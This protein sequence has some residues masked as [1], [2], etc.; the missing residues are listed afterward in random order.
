MM[1]KH[2]NQLKMMQLNIN[3]CGQNSIVA[4]NRYINKEKADV[5]F[6]SE[7]KTSSLD[8]SDFDNYQVILKPNK[9]KPTQRGGTAI[10]VHNCIAA[11]RMEH[12]EKENTD[13]TFA[14]L[15]LDRRRILVCSSYVPPN[16]LDLLR[17]TEEQIRKATCEMKSLRCSSFAAFGDFNSRHVQWKDH[18]TNKHGEEL[19]Q[20]CS[21]NNLHIPSIHSNKTFICNTG[22]SLIDIAI[23]DHQTIKLITNQ[24]VDDSEELFTG[25][26]SRGHIPVWTTL[27][28]YTPKPLA[29]T[30][31]S[32]S[33]ADWLGF[34][35]HLETL[36][37]SCLFEI[38]FL[39]P[40]E[41]WHTILSNLHQCKELFVPKI[42]ISKY[43]KPY[44][45]EELTELSKK[46]REARKAFRHRSTYANGDHLD[47]T[48][49]KFKKALIEAQTMFIESKSANLN[50]AEDPQFWKSF[51]QTFY[52]SAEP[53][54]TAINKD[55]DLILDD[56]KKADTFFEEIFGG[57]H[58]EG[59]HFSQSW[60]EEVTDNLNIHNN[61]KFMD[62]M[63]KVTASE[64]TDAIKVTKTNGK[65]ADGDGIHPSMLKLSG[66]QFHI[67]LLVLFNKIL[68]TRRWPFTDNN[69]VVF[70]RKPGRKDYTDTANYRPITLSSV[71]GKLLERIIEARLRN[72]IEQ[73]NWLGPNQH[74]FRKK[75]STGTYLSQLIT[76][77]QHNT[78]RHYATAGLF[79]DLQKAFDSVW[80]NGMIYRLAE[81]GFGGHFIELISS[82]LKDR[83]IK[84]RV[85]G[86]TSEAKS[87]HIGL[88]QGSVLSPL[89]F[90]V[91]IRDMLSSIDGLSLQYADDCSIVCSKPD[92]RQLQDTLESSCERIS[93]WLCKWRLKANCLKTD[94]I[95][96]KGQPTQ[97]KISGEYINIASK[98]KVLGVVVD[99]KL[100]FKHQKDVAK[101][102]LSRKWRMLLPFI[103][104]GLRPSV[105][106]K[107]LITTIL[108]K[109]LY[110][111]YIWDTQ[112]EMSL[113]SCLKDLLGV[114]FNPATDTL[115]KLANI[116]TIHVRYTGDIL[117][118]C[119]LSIEGSTMNNILDQKKSSLQHRIRCCIVRLLGRHFEEYP[120]TSTQFKKSNVQKFLKE[121]ANRT[122][123]SHLKQG[124]N[125][126]GLLSQLDAAH[127][128]KVPVPLNLPRQIIGKLCSLLTGQTKLQAFLYKVNQ[129]Y[130]PTCSCLME[131]E[132]VSHYVYRCQNYQYLR[133]R[134]YVDPTDHMSL[135]SYV[136]ES[137]RLNR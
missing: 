85:N 27:D 137:G 42:M 67:N 63:S 110:N 92:D 19:L 127:L 39:E 7:T 86:H 83:K 81:L 74:G 23:V 97:M 103:R 123:K 124:H 57:K 99:Q 58:L 94:V 18:T 101:S 20:F 115:H 53:V 46:V 11:D 136:K 4:L 13:T 73:N 21:N 49:E 121:E 77:I 55:G 134:L 122:W 118:L 70:L 34:H 113:H 36:S 131:D 80:H 10:L 96:F 9:T 25:A 108:P 5:I 107:I 62:I 45:T 119:K 2:S 17:A 1:D 100:T 61:N 93:Q 54:I 41:I 48:K 88:P 66:S 52:R 15:T 114:P 69:V 91:Y 38:Q 29:K 117:N 130:T 32:W 106:R 72:I 111:A 47:D 78:S 120:L 64:L 44:W 40:E 59:T 105:T 14:A 82:F 76:T 31:Y 60:F 56:V 12:L 37:S 128:D 51:R 71:V 79:V 35:D 126:E 112:E 16:N 50:T 125:S 22:G 6:L 102:T 135:I 116:P 98:T 68:E 87:C 65:G 75:K 104:H 33:R 3:G 89:L 8:E 109:V 84:I 24:Y 30:I 133:V 26:P 90:I 95:Y 43:S 129:S 132:T 28:L